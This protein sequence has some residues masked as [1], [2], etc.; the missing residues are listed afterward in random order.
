[1]PTVMTLLLA[2]FIAQDA[3][4]IVDARSATDI[5][6]VAD[7]CAELHPFTAF[8][9][10]DGD[11]LP[12]GDAFGEFAGDEFG[13]ADGDGPLDVDAEVNNI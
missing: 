6:R 7:F 12:D 1:M 8:T 9:I 3:P 11:E 13:C 5:V 2:A 10:A 4:G